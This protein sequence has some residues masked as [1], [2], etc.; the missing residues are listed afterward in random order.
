MADNKIEIIAS[1]DIPKSKHNIADELKQLQADIQADKSMRPKII[2]GL[3]ISKSKTLIQSQLDTIVNQANAPTIKVGIDVSSTKNISTAI[4][5]QLGKTNVADRI[6]NSF[7]KTIDVIKKAE[8]EFRELFNVTKQGDVTGIWNKDTNG[9]I[10]GFTVNVKKA[11][12]ETES[13][14]Y[15]L[16][17]V[18]E[19]MQFVYAGG[20]GSD[21][22]V[23]KLQQYADKI[24]ALRTSLTS[25]LDG[26]KQGY[27]DTNVTKPITDSSNIT[28]LNEQYSKALN[29]INELKN[30]DS[31]TMAS[32][33]ANAEKEIDSLKRLVKQ[34]Q[35]AEYAAT[36]LRDKGIDTTKQIELNNLN[37][38]SSQISGSNIKD[39]SG[40][41]SEVERLK[42]MLNGSFDKNVLTDYLNQV[43]ILKSKFDALNTEAK[44]L[45][46]LQKSI[47]T[48]IGNL[49]SKKLNSTFTRNNTNPEVVQQ[50]AKIDE[51]KAKYQNLLSLISQPQTPE[52]LTKLRNETL[53]LD[54]D[55]QLLIQSVKNF[56]GTLRNDKAIDVNFDKIKQLRAEIQAYMNLNPKAMNMKL[57][58]GN[59]VGAELNRMLSQLNDLAS[60]ELVASIDRQ[61]K[62][63]GKTVV[64][65]GKEG[66][67]VLGSLLA[68]AKKFGT[69]MGITGFISG[70]IRNI[71]KMI[72]NVIEL[73]TA[74]TNLKKVTDETTATYSKFFDSATERAKKLHTAV[75]DLIEQTAMW[76]KLG[77]GLKDAQK[78][79]ETSTIYAKVGE[80]DNETAVSDLVTVMKSFNIEAQNSIRIV[81]MLNILGNNFATDAKSLGEG[82]AKAASAMNMGGNSL[83]QS[84]AM[85][86]GGTEITQNSSEMANAIKVFTMR[87][88]GMKGSLEELGEE[89]E[90]VESISKTQTHI[91]N[92]TS[93]KVN[94]FDAERNFRS[95]YDVLKDVSEILDDLSSTDRADL[96][97]T[98]FGKMRGNQGMAI[99]QAFQSGQIEKAYETALNSAGSAQEEFNKW[100]DSAE[101]KIQKFK[102]QFESLS[103]S[104]FDTKDIKFLIDSGTTLLSIVEKIVDTLGTIPTIAGA[105]TGILALK[106]NNSW[107]QTIAND[108][109]SLRL[110]SSL[111]ARQIAQQQAM[112]QLNADERALREY[113]QACI[114]GTVTTETFSK[115]MQ[116]ASLQAQQYAIQIKNG[117]GSTDIYV[118]QQR[119]LQTQITA[120]S[121]TTKVANGVVKGLSVAFSML[122]TTAIVWGISFAVEQIT[123]L[124]QASQEA[125]DTSKELRQEFEQQTSNYSSNRKTLE[126][127]KDEYESLAKHVDEHGNAIGLSAD[128]Y[129]RYKDITSQILGITPQLIT[130]WDEEGQAISN[131]NNLIQQSIDLLDEEYKKSIRN[132]TTKSKNEKISKGLV[133]EIKKY[134]K[135]SKKDIADLQNEVA[136]ELSNTLFNTPYGDYEGVNRYFDIA[137]EIH[138][139]AKD[140]L[141]YRNSDWREAFENYISD[142][143]LVSFDELADFLYKDNSPIFNYFSEEAIDELRMSANDFFDE[144]NRIRDERD[145]LYDEFAKQINLNIQA[146]S[147][148]YFSLSSSSK[149]FVDE[150]VKSLDY[151]SIKS[152]DDF[153]KMTKDAEDFVSSLWK[154]K[155]LQEQIDSLVSLNNQN[156]PIDEYISQ[157]KSIVNNI[158]NSL[159]TQ[160]I[161]LPINFTSNIEDLERRYETVISKFGDKDKEILKEFFNSNSINTVEEI[162]N[163]AK[164]TEGV[165]NATLAIQQYILESNKLDGTSINSVFDSMSDGKLKDSYEKIDKFKDVL[166]DISEGNTIDRDTAWELFELD[167]NKLI[168]TIDLVGDEYD[169]SSEEVIKAKDEIVQATINEIRAEIAAGEARQKSIKQSIELYKQR[170]ASYGTIGLHEVPAVTYANKQITSLNKEWEDTVASTNEW[171]KALDYANASLGDTTKKTKQTAKDLEKIAD[172]YLNAF[173]DQIDKITDSLENQKETLEDELETLEEQLDVL[174]KQKETLEETI[175]NYETI[176]DYISE[177]VR[178]E[179]DALKE[180]QEELENSYDERITSIEEF[181]DS[182]IEKLQEANKERERN[183]E[184]EEKLLA[185]ENAKKKRVKVYNETSGSFE[186]RGDQDAAM[187]ARK[188][189]QETKA[190]FELE[191]KI[192]KLEKTRDELVKQIE[193][194]KASVTDSFESQIEALEEY[195]EKWEEI[196]KE[197]TDAEKDMLAEQIFGSE[198][199]EKIKNKDTKILTKFKTSYKNYNTELKNLVSGEIAS[200]EKSIEAKEKDIEA[201]QKEID[202]WNDYKDKVQQAAKDIENS[203]NGYA[204]MLNNIKLDESSNFAEREA[205]LK[206]FT[207]KYVGYLQQIK[208]MQDQISGASIGNITLDVGQIKYSSEYLATYLEAIL[209]MRKALQESSTGYGLVNSEHDAKIAHAAT[210]IDDELI[211]AIEAFKKLKGYSSGGTADRTGLAMLHGTK[212]SAETIFNASDSK[213][214][215]N[216][217]HNTDNLSTMLANNVMKNINSDSRLRNV[218]STPSTTINNWSFGDI[219]ANSPVEFAKQMENY[220][221]QKATESLVR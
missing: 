7:N 149:A 119:Q 15:V 29:T 47:T 19:E 82:M 11:K 126:D 135:T 14:K 190:N 174:E 103:V 84:L 102:A 58:G 70:F 177:I 104:T 137:D 13:F 183:I 144:V 10:N 214:L 207:E 153:T 73:D 132:A 169:L 99:L 195:A 154:N 116:N 22:G 87:I 105:I 167:E 56:Q 121:A 170:I 165:N 157:Y 209:A 186:Y 131:K 147:G 39:I 173:T 194:E 3:D 192:S 17:Q 36:S 44:T 93:G 150:Y 40:L 196:S 136:L 163:W 156:L 85:L 218:N 142:T 193:D 176:A 148:E 18:G 62:T 35:N 52:S 75:S 184:L 171:R 201:K 32:M 197:V 45:A 92:L 79:A 140:D 65:M 180:Q 179:A 202:S 8:Q 200:L 95:T 23:Y 77:Y 94:I 12:G 51:L 111:K 69:W 213:K 168:R 48:A 28:K 57:V 72:T 210:A 172:N 16:K 216:L 101:A 33:K 37:K 115:S 1:L 181:Y 76:A 182:E 161:S 6:T 89:Y 130:G 64:S 162:N 81:D 71:R 46:D 152:E 217:I 211:K 100:M 34:F 178:D 20:R 90:N 109:G 220:W 42:S 88:Q 164:L 5:E 74:M 134:N 9:N 60:P 205:A 127:L 203:L 24:K 31:I 187:T 80:V 189:V 63:I 206:T 129:E 158:E 219:V 27:L 2:A 68:S 107:F 21:S 110:I 120:T 96:L 112:T 125:I 91:L 38:L 30:A 198:W 128:E 41:L 199:R 159:S 50:I 123:K 78:L 138:K 106:S 67:T 146:H 43:D 4:N 124:A 141:S 143:S 160:D 215:Y 114:D 117:T 97:E 188:E 49:D 145:L 26:I 25:K 83:E 86:T 59:T 175:D 54:R 55:Y 212:S 221:R 98:L 113:E 122:K 53:L 61:F 155:G 133:K 166:K 204:D 151:A 118:A 185:L 208:S 108:D 139:G 191:D 66:N